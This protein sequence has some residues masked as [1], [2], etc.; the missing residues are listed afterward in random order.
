MSVTGH[1]V[2]CS[3]AH[4]RLISLPFRLVTWSRWWLTVTAD[5]S[6]FRLV[7][8]QVCDSIQAS[9]DW[10]ERDLEDVAQV[11]P[12]ALPL[13][14]SATYTPGTCSVLTTPVA[15]VQLV[16]LNE[17]TDRC[18]PAINHKIHVTPVSRNGDK[19]EEQKHAAALSVMV[20]ALARLTDTQKRDC[21][22]RE[23]ERE[24]EKAIGRASPLTTTDHSTTRQCHHQA[25]GPT[26]NH[27][28][29]TQKELRSRDSG[30]RTVQCRRF[31]HL[32]QHNATVTQ[33]R[34]SSRH[35]LD[36]WAW[37]WV[38]G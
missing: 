11:G 17:M 13:S 9:A 34:A 1:V 37:T 32:T 29:T 16:P 12:N 4:A 14:S 15:Q 27:E 38:H 30:G 8:A 33:R 25:G 24:R 26:A 23:R 36:A 22:E 28:A 5:T 10:L 18:W 7:V 3:C 31:S 19:E 21:H 35:A 6:R 20:M 2:M